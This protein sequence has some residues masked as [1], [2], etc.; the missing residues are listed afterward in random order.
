MLLTTKARLKFLFPLMALRNMMR[1]SPGSA[2]VVFEVHVAGNVV[3][4][5]SNRYRVRPTAALPGQIDAILR[6]KGACQLVGPVN[7]VKADKRAVLEE[8]EATVANRLRRE[9]T[10]EAFCDSIDRY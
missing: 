2:K 1:Q 7:L 9:A 4:L 8:G 10:E 5:Q 6:T 3:Y